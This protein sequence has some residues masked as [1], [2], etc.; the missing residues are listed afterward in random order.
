MESL[1][2]LNTNVGRLIE[3]YNALLH[4]L[5][6]NREYTVRLQQELSEAHAKTLAVQEANKYMKTVAGVLGD[7]SHRADFRKTLT[8]LIAQCDEL[9]EVLK[10]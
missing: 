2:R 9:L 8:E 7:I 10:K 6:A 4:E 3:R 5:Q 1:D